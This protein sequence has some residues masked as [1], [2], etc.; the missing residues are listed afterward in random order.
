MIL[1]VMALETPATRE[2]KPLEMRVEMTEEKKKRRPSYLKLVHSKAF[3]PP[4]EHKEEPE[5][6][7]I[8]FDKPPRGFRD[9]IHRKGIDLRTIT[10]GIGA[11]CIMCASV[12]F[13]LTMLLLSSAS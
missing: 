1:T 10:M 2:V 9:T 13:M 6:E 7:S 11:L 4:T 5:Q 8:D 12:V 3:E